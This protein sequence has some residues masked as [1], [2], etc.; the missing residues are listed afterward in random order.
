MRFT[1]TTAIEYARSG[2]LETWIHAYITTGDWANFALSNGLRQQQ[3]WWIGPVVVNVSDL[4]R[5]CGPEP[6]MKFL[7]EPE[8]WE[9][10]ITELVHSITD[11]LTVPP[12]I[13]EYCSGTF[14]IR[15]GN[16][17]HEAVRRKGWQTCWVIIWH[18]SEADFL[19]DPYRSRVGENL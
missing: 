12:L 16:H 4:V 1:V 11:P 13:V 9:R 10:R 8:H 5:V 17:R 15:D 2:Q 6:S 14:S 7:V 19:S 18:N 3:R